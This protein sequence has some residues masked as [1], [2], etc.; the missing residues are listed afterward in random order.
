M[1]RLLMFALL[2]IALSVACGPNSAV[3]VPDGYVALD[4]DD[5]SDDVAQ[6]M[7][8]ADGAVVVVR[9]RDNDP[10]GNLDFW[11]E[12]LEREIQEGQGYD[13][14]ATETIDSQSGKGRLLKFKGAYQEETFHYHV[15]LFTT[16]SLIVTVETVVSESNAERHANTLL[17]TISSLSIDP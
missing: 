7:V 2:L 16:A 6:K 9:E 15:A 4:D 5:L 10:Y 3:I 14:V 17:D 1:T 8:S 11:T 12:A 13:L